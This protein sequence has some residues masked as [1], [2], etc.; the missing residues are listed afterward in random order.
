MINSL[1]PSI[2]RSAQLKWSWALTCVSALAF[3]CETIEVDD[4][5]YLGDASPLAT[6][7]SD[8]EISA[9]SEWFSEVDRDPPSPPAPVAGV[10]APVP[11]GGVEAGAQAGAQAGAPPPPPQPTAQ[12]ETTVR[13]AGGSLELETNLPAFAMGCDPSALMDLSCDDLDE[14]GLVDAWEEALLEH[15]RP[16]LRFH[17]E[18]PLLS[19]PSAPI[20]QLGRVSVRTTSPLEVNLNIVTLFPNSESICFVPSRSGDLELSM[21]KVTQ[22]DNDVY[23]VTGTRLPPTR[24]ISSARYTDRTTEVLSSGGGAGP[25]WLLYSLRKQH[26]LFESESSCV[27]STRFVCEGHCSSDRST[28]LGVHDRLPPITH[29]GERSRPLINE[30]DT[31]GYPEERAW[32]EGVFCGGMDVGRFGRCSEQSIQ[33]LLLTFFEG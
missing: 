12:I 10:S 26:T 5:M 22:V 17:P 25:R 6:G 16:A 1:Q 28:Q 8:M 27:N 24:L 18:E 14:D 32:D 2:L 30:L 13:L 31:L 15:F 11:Q 9:P 23:R 33:E 7:V 3:A 4:T 29:V 20:I 19:G 21:L